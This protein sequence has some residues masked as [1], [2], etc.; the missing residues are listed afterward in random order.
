M[1]KT[2]LLIINLV[3]VVGLLVLPGVSEA[4]G[5]TISE[6]MQAAALAGEI[7][8][9]SVDPT[10][11][12]KVTYNVDFTL[13]EGD[14]AVFFPAGTEMTRTGGGN[15]NLLAMTVDDIVNSLKNV[16]DGNIAGALS[17]G[18]PNLNLSFS[19]NITVTIP[20]GSAYNGQ[21]L[22]IYYQ[23]AGESD[24]ATGTSCTVASGLC[25]FQTNHAT[26]YSVGDKPTTSDDDSC[27]KKCKLYKKYKKDFK[28]ATNKKYYQELKLLK[29][30]N[31]ILFNK[32]K[33]IDDKYKKA[34]KTV[35]A[36]LDAKTLEMYKKYH[37]YH[38]YKKYLQ[39]K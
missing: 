37:S 23:N 25:I 5:G 35:R 31:P 19:H 26:K 2:K 16:Y 24:W 22:S 10:N 32:M 28:S 1:K 11:A 36:K 15:M 39:Y 6:R 20:V 34:G 38:G 12:G 17:I 18:I 8:I 21:T 30:T 3:A 9:D 27:G 7:T 13:E 29:K 4:T 33:A 14:A